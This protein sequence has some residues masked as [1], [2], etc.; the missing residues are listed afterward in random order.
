MG[1]IQFQLGAQNTKGEAARK[2]PERIILCKAY[3]QWNINRT[4]N[5]I[6]CR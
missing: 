3:N 4:K 1:D 2:L 5:G 6:C